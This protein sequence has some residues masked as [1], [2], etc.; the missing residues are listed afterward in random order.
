MRDAAERRPLSADPQGQY[1]PE[2]N[3]QKCE[4]TAHHQGERG[5]TVSSGSA[6]LS[7][8]SLLQAPQWV[9]RR[10]TTP[11]Q[12]PIVTENCGG[13]PVSLLLSRSIRD[14]AHPCTT[15]SLFPEARGCRAH[16]ADSRNESQEMEVPQ[17]LGRHATALPSSH[18]SAG[19]PGTPSSSP[20]TASTGELEIPM[21][22]DSLWSNIDRY[23]FAVYTTLQTGDESSLR[24]LR[25][26][27]HRMGW[28]TVIYNACSGDPTKSRELYA[29]L[30]LLLLHIL[31]SHVL[32]PILQNV[33]HNGVQFL[34]GTEGD[35]GTR[36][37]SSPRQSQSSR[38]APTGS[39]T[40]GGSG[41]SRFKSIATAVKSAS[42]HGI[43]SSEISRN[44]SFVGPATGHGNNNGSFAFVKR[45][46]H[47]LSNPAI[48]ASAARASTVVGAGSHANEG[49][50][51]AGQPS[52]SPK[53]P[54]PPG[55]ANG[56]S[57][58]SSS[59][60]GRGT[61]W[62]RRQGSS[63]RW[64]A[65]RTSIPSGPPQHF[66]SHTSGMGY[67]SRSHSRPRSSG[68]LA[69]PESSAAAN[70]LQ[71]AF[72]G[73]DCTVR[74]SPEERVALEPPN[75]QRQSAGF[76]AVASAQPRATASPPV[77]PTKAAHTPLTPSSVTSRHSAQQTVSVPT[78]LNRFTL[79][80]CARTSIGG[81]ALPTA[82]QRTA[83]HHHARVASKTG[84]VL[85]DDEEEM[86]CEVYTVSPAARDSTRQLQR[87]GSRSDSSSVAALASF[88]DTEAGS[89]GSP[90]QADDDDSLR[91]MNS[92]IVSENLGRE[93][94]LRTGRYA[95]DGANAP[96]AR[97]GA[98]G[99]NAARAGTGPCTDDADEVGTMA[100]LPASGSPF[101]STLTPGDRTPSPLICT[102][103]STTLRSTVINAPPSS[104]KTAA[105]AVVTSELRT[106]FP[107]TKTA[108]D[109]S[110]TT[111]GTGAHGAPLSSP[112]VAV[113]LA[114]SEASATSDTAS[115]SPP[116][117]AF[118]AAAKTASAACGTGTARPDERRFSLCYTFLQEW[119]TFLVFRSVVLSCFR[120]LDQYYTRRF[121]MDTITLMCFKVFYV[122]VYEPLQPLLVIELRHLMQYV[123]EV[124][125]ATS[126][127]AW[128]Q[129]R[130][131]QETYSVMTELLLLVQ[132]ASSSMVAQQQ[133]PQAG[134]GVSGG[135]GGT[136][137]TATVGGSNAIG[138]SSKFA[139]SSVAAAV[140][141]P[142][143]RPATAEVAAAETPVQ[144]HAS[145]RARSTTSGQNHSTASSAASTPRVGALDPHIV[146]STVTAP[147]PSPGDE[148]RSG[149]RPHVSRRHRLIS[150]L[151]SGRLGD[152]LKGGSNSGRCQRGTSTPVS[153]WASPASASTSAAGLPSAFERNSSTSADG[154]VAPRPQ[155]YGDGDNGR[156]PA[157]A[158]V[159]CR[160][161]KQQGSTTVV[162]SISA[163]PV[164]VDLR[165]T[166]ELHDRLAGNTTTHIL[167]TQALK[168]WEGMAAA[169]R[170]HLGTIVKEIA[171]PLATIVMEDVG[172]EYI[173]G[174]YA[175]YRCTR[176]AH[177]STEEGRRG[178]V[179][180]ASGV[181]ELEKH[182]WRR[183][184][185]PF[186]HTSLRSALNEVLVVEPH[187][188]ILLDAR[189]GL[190]ALLD[191]WSSSVEAA[192]LSL[193]PQMSAAAA[194]PGGAAA[195]A[196][197]IRGA[198]AAALHWRTDSATTSTSLGGGVDEADPL[199]S[200]G[201]QPGASKHLKSP[202]SPGAHGSLS[203]HASPL[204]HQHAARTFLRAVGKTHE[205]KSQISFSAAAGEE[206][207]GGRR[208]GKGG[209]A[210]SEAQWT[211]A[212]RSHSPIT[213]AAVASSI[214]YSSADCFTA[215]VGA[216]AGG[217]RGESETS[218]LGM[219]TM[220]CMTSGSN[221]SS[222][223]VPKKAATD[224]VLAPHQ[225]LGAQL[226]LSSGTTA[227]V[228]SRGTFSGEGEGDVASALA[229]LESLYRLFS[230]VTEDECFVLM[231]AIII[232]KL[233]R[234]AADIIEQYLRAVSGSVSA[235]PSPP[236]PQAAGIQLMAGLVEL[237][238]RYTDLVE[239]AFHSHAIVHRALSDAIEELMRPIRW[240]RKGALQT[241]QQRAHEALMAAAAA[242]A[243]KA[244]TVGGSHTPASGAGADLPNVLLSR[245][246][247]QATLPLVELAA[248]Y[249][250]AVQQLRLSTLVARYADVLLQQER[251]GGRVLSSKLHKRL[252]LIAQLVPLLEDKDTF[253]EH[254]RL[255]L[256]RRL[257]GYASGTAD[258]QFG[259]PSGSAC[260]VVG[261]RAKKPL[262]VGH[263]F[264]GTSAA[265]SLNM[266][267]ERQ[268]VS[269]LQLYLGATGTHAFEAMLRDYEGTERRRELFEQ[270][271]A[272][273]ELPAKI[274]VQLITSSQWPTYAMPP[275]QT[276]ISLQRGMDVFRAHYAR[277]HPSRTLLWVFSLGS[278]TLSVELVSGTKQVVAST[279]LAT[280]LLA[281]SDAYNAE[282]ADAAQGGAL[283]GAQ[284]AHILGL[285]FHS[286]RAH[287]HLLTHH[288]AFHFLRCIPASIGGAGAT[289]ATAVAS[290]TESDSF[291]LNPFY[292]HKLRKIR[293]PLPWARPTGLPPGDAQTFGG[294]LELASRPEP[295][296]TPSSPTS[297]T[298]A[299]PVTV[300]T[301]EDAVVARHVHAT[302]RVLLDAALVRVFKCRRVALFED[303]L[304][305]VT[306][307]LS[308]QFVP[309]RR[310]V[311]AQLEGLIDRDYV[312]RSPK[313]PNTFIY[314]A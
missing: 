58:A 279:I 277:Q 22:F 170:L 305:T 107:G 268:L 75:Q 81:K 271:A 158:E 256:A 235:A 128:E 86:L 213:V 182:V 228:D 50:G 192:G 179:E 167:T 57:V 136:A 95:G 309:S 215:H 51:G 177:R 12:Q 171:K 67:A 125:E 39:A 24:P 230:D 263:T 301:D 283:T 11:P 16:S 30:A 91:T 303:L 60:S 198:A 101:T 41:W 89:A 193:A 78:E 135:G 27:K 45:L 260:G 82:M 155:A 211:T 310:D 274:R 168:Q 64:S 35:A 238:E 304:Q 194:R 20:T 106:S 207:D 200:S 63:T 28:Y 123:R 311:K 79:M 113:A 87:W 244:E 126:W 131:I 8:A 151:I 189:F 251:G 38:N 43:P 49:E 111:A 265:T 142:L 285:P 17:S 115:S 3:H 312:K 173:A 203:S 191:V 110:M 105:R 204:P 140:S 1:T 257:L 246:A 255:C 13:M 212:T 253:L 121:G 223:L 5:Y 26:P 83:H 163:P 293:L 206:E 48:A 165:G 74:H 307:Q 116:T 93:R 270:E 55:S 254:Y 281:V 139:A 117:P 6:V 216:W 152:G 141:A 197:G 53:E 34:T 313:D 9:F 266:E 296:A 19:S 143:A 273:K 15:G 129:L 195:R 286:L 287:L 132:S 183:V 134:L 218:A 65:A 25:T 137:A 166:V 133:Q 264:H 56:I 85:L 37:S 138:A 275:L 289:A 52:Q 148:E 237:M 2:G 100:P 242:A 97:V 292:T 147:S 76:S 103:P 209:G 299:A 118:S 225:E 77:S 226:S 245:D 42:V 36:R 71:T 122:V 54:A 102:Q 73:F 214:S 120:Y 161:A 181:K 90:T 149:T 7:G 302:R 84:R 306:A 248:N 62:F 153:P 232:T 32:F 261:G 10:S 31:E 162:D 130:L 145:S 159:D 190:R 178:Y 297:D 150:R 272:Y 47:P 160:G 186:L 96:A 127:V 233:I 258:P 239:G 240:T 227:A 243:A 290:I 199:A 291:S 267:A 300:N 88:N 298:A 262:A 222:H 33:D 276:H 61:N 219:A 108:S 175:F 187:R 18:P 184:Q 308:R 46:L 98:G 205:R 104:P 188:S 295:S 282:G 174:I 221:S 154:K 294:D 69:V 231:A 314:L 249:P 250:Q 247:R 23:L 269:F 185:L 124:F 156:L 4:D 288:R 280:L 21:A 220:P 144:S 99:R 176:E 217:G 94:P 180:W 29:R 164:V 40:A 259:S 72:F 284:L 112:D 119:Q 241:S 59:V 208:G 66:V 224:A 201:E 157:R 80:E 92:S 68:D 109:I 146:S 14:Q 210:L 278:A 252:R 202:I 229:A 196:C 234:D 114:A 172:N 236:H 70:E 169:R 44:S